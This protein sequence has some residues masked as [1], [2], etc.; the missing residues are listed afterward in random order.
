MKPP[1]FSRY[2][3]LG[4]I[5]TTTI[6]MVVV[7]MGRIQTST[8]ADELR[9]QAQEYAGQT[10]TIYPERGDIYD[11][12]GHL[13][14]GNKQVYEVGAELQNVTDPQTIAAAVS[15]VTGADFATVLAAA[16]IPYASGKSEYSKLVDSVTP[17]EIA[18]L[19]ALQKQYAAQASAS[20]RGKPTPSLSGL[21]WSPYLERSYPEGTLAANVLGFYNYLDRNNGR[22]YFGVEEKYNDLLAGT[23]QQVFVPNDPNLVQQIPEVPPGA[24]LIL[25][26]DREIQA[27]V[28]KILDE[29]VKKTGATSGTI[30]VSDPRT[31]E[32]LAMATTPEM[33]PNQYWNYS[34]IFPSPTPYNRAI[35]QTYEPGSVFKVLTMAAALDTSTVT[36][37][38]PFLDTGSI[39]IGGIYI[40]NWD[41]GAWGPQTMLGCMQHSLNVCLAW[42]GTQLGPTKFYDYV[43]AF[44]I[45]NKTGIDL[46]GEVNWP[47]RLPGDGQWFP[48]DLGTN[49]F[50]QGVAVTPIQ[51][52]MA[53]DA[54]ANDGKMMA[55]HILRSM[56]ENGRQYNTPPQVVGTPISAETAHTLTAMLTQ[57]LE[58][59]SSDALV[60]GYSMAGKTGTASIP[61]E[62]GYSSSLTNASFV[63]WG[64][65]DNPQFLVYIWLEKPQTS[66]WG[67]VVAAPVFS[68]VVKSLV[69]LMD[70]PP[71]NLRKQSNGQ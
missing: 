70:I 32:I 12:W 23:P 49:S 2:I 30:I 57:S 48:V 28:E 39:E 40:H 43:R 5:F 46:A 69:V 65:S 47:L 24:S 18:Q 3:T 36:P 29:N 42:V 22:G 8:T 66:E 56:I 67:S 14:A 10:E 26:I 17:E 33:D 53:I 50:G 16:S 62:T 52:V 44:G 51:M 13:L 34:E 63:G 27:S 37:D 6:S 59:E 58:G 15:S 54:V 64:P 71:D 11:R 1:F 4:V 60:P 68:E 35:G 41:G 20:K 25:T 19:S 9:K 45:G 7:Q 21:I 61:T 31:G 38:T 55:P